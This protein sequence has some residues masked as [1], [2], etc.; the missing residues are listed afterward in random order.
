M[1]SF[2]YVK[3]ELKASKTEIQAANEHLRDQ[4]LAMVGEYMNFTGVAP[5]INVKNISGSE[6]NGVFGVEV[7]A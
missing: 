2:K 4:I 1:K 6:G 5:F 7:R 3:Q